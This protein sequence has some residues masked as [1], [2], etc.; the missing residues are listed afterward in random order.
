VT[1]TSIEVHTSGINNM[2]GGWT[3]VCTRET[4]L[5]RDIVDLGNVTELLC[6]AQIQPDVI[7]NVRLGV[8]SA[9]ADISGRFTALSLPSG[10]FEIPL[11]P[12]ANVQAGKTATII[13]DFQPHIVC[14][15][16]ADCK[17][18]PALHATFQHST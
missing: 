3:Q 12:V 2:T 4:P 6:G 5:T 18:T 8:T 14:Q 1:V 13:V 16:S 15:G 7:T 11:S 10:K 9:N 17:L